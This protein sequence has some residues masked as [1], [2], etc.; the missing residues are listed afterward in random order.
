M[1]ALADEELSGL[2]GHR[3]ARGWVK[4]LTNCSD[5]EASNL[6]RTGKPIHDIPECGRKLAVGDVGVARN[7]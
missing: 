1:S 5:A 2:E 4:A 3:S 7:P 6:A